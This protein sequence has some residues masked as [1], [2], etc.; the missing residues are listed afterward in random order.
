MG[1]L[2]KIRMTFS[3]PPGEGRGAVKSISWKD[4]LKTRCWSTDVTDGK[5]LVTVPVTRALQELLRKGITSQK[6]KQSH[7]RLRIWAF[8]CEWHQPPDPH[9]ISESSFS[10]FFWG[11]APLGQFVVGLVLT[12]SHSVVSDSLWPH[13]LW[14]ARLC[15]QGF[16]GKNTGVGCQALLQG[17]L[18]NPGIEPRSP[19]LQA[20]L[21]E[22]IA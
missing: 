19:T 16:S 8:A 4:I 9:F 7:A 22:F 21:E 20:S 14:P 1:L 15:P 12:I 17:N 10:L 13:G 18:L 11:T 3:S 5:P 6:A 2:W